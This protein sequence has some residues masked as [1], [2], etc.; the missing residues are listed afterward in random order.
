MFK[1]ASLSLA[2]SLLVL[3]SC[4]QNTD[5]SGSVPSEEGFASLFD[6][7]SLNGWK[8]YMNDPVEKAWSVQDGVMALKG[9]SPK[10][11]Y[12]NIMTEAE[13]DD[14]D[15][16]W[17][18]KLESGS[19]SGLMFHVKEGPKMPYLTG[20]EYQMLDNLGFRGGDGKPVPPNEYTASHY[21]IEPAYQEVTKPIGE[22]NSSRILVV[23]NIVQYWLNGIKTADYEM[24]S[25]KWNQQIAAAKFG[26]WK[27]FGTTGSGHIALQDHGHGAWIRNIRIKELSK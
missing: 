1:I 4:N 24:H 10:G 13:F 18:W 14:F 21:A 23:G 15:L 19:N 17:E 3:A 22:W 25:E 11:S 20:P 27:Q 2:L 6:G 8:A 26:K 5:T 9:G 16:R 7:K 12:A